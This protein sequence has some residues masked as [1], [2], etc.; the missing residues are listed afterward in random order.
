MK[1]IIYLISIVV[2]LNASNI[3][4]NKVNMGNNHFY[5]INSDKE[6]NIEGSL[7]FTYDLN[8]H[9]GA[10]DNIL[11]NDMNYEIHG[12]LLPLKDIIFKDIKKLNYLKIPLKNNK[13]EKYLYI[14]NDYKFKDTTYEVLFNYI[15]L[16]N[17]KYNKQKYDTNKFTKIYNI[18][19]LDL[20]N[21][22]NILKYN[23]MAYYLQK[24]G[25][26][27]EAIFILEK[28]LK[29]YPNRTVAYYNIADAYWDIDDKIN[30]IKYYKIYVKQ[31]KEK[32]KENK[33][34]QKIVSRIN[35]K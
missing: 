33:I 8:C 24:A 16:I 5:Y 14:Y 15:F 35:V 1:I 2:Y 29:K 26:S 3:E 12:N 9:T 34:P 23:N 22:N 6:W 25:A 32:N 10:S 30:A 27:K 21:K 4:T 18:N 20:N 31:M 13:I 19:Y 17:N 11:C 28:I 7:L